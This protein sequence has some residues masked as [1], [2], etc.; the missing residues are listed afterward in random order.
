MTY[1]NPVYCFGVER[2]VKLASGSGVDGIIVP[3]LPPEEAFHLIRFSRKADFSTI[4]LLAPTSVNK[5]IKLISKASTGFIYYVSLTGVTGARK[6]LPVDIKSDVARIKNFT[7]KP[8]C[9]GF[10]ISN[11]CQARYIANLSDGVIIG[12]A[13]IKVMQKNLKSAAMVKKAGNFIRSLSNAIRR[14]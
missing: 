7:A 1:Y 13:V 10:G 12:S 11:P 4:F 8:V 6:K 9:V 5:R 14:S 2:L 3:D